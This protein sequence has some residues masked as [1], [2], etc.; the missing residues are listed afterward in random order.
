MRTTLTLDD[1]LVRALKDLAH[2]SARSFKDVVN[3]TLRAGLSQ[4][5]RGSARKYTLRPAHLGEVTAGVNLDQ[6]LRLADRLEDLEVARK[7]ELRK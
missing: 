2:R 4:T 1:A 5:G 3:D 6:A 7:L